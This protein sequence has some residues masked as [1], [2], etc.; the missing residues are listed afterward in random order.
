MSKGENILYVMGES[1]SGKDS[2]IKGVLNS[3]KIVDI[4]FPVIYAPRYITRGI[5]QSENHI[6]IHDEKQFDLWDEL[7]LFSM[8]WRAHSNIYAIDKRIDEWDDNGITVVVSGSREYYPTAKKLYPGLNSVLIK[9]PSLKVAE[10]RLEKRE[11]EEQSEIEE[12]KKRNAKFASV[13]FPDAHIIVNEE[14][15][16]DKSIDQFIQ[17]L[18]NIMEFDKIERYELS[19]KGLYSLNNDQK[20]GKVI[21]KIIQNYG[22]NFVDIGKMGKIVVTNHIRKESPKIYHNWDHFLKDMSYGLEEGIIQRKPKKDNPK[23]PNDYTWRINPEI[24]PYLT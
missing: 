2:V 15:E 10:K 3:K 8:S 20:L 11:R 18:Y 4:D 19:E 6:V 21:R 17:I 24:M 1:G 5:E 12:R 9:A 22:V 13:E 16:L 23:V 14:G 7:G